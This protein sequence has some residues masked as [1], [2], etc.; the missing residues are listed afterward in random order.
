MAYEYGKAWRIHVGDGAGSEVFSALGGEG[1]FDWQRQ[2]DEIDFTTKD[3]AVYKNSGYGLQS[4]TFNVQGKL[5]LP[6][7]ALERIDT[8]AKSGTPEVNIKIM[9]GATEKFVGAV[10]VGNFS[11]SFPSD[12]AATFS[13]TARN[14]GAPSTDNLGA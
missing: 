4:I 8:I 9:K 10:A 13:F 5:K 14:V 3:D 1:S 12:G 6:D 2:S 7:T 11:C